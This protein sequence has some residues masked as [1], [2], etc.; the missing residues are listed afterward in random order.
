MSELASSLTL[1]GIVLVDIAIGLI[2]AVLVFSLIAS[3]INE[4]I[5]GV[6]NFRGEHLLKGMARIV[7]SRAVISEVLAQPEI[8]ALS[9]PSNLLQRSIQRLL[10]PKGLTIGT[11]RLPSAI[12]GQTFARSL[13]DALVKARLKTEHELAGSQDATSRALAKINANIDGLE[14]GSEL[15]ARLKEV[16]SRIDPDR[17]RNT[18]ADRLDGTLDAASEAVARRLEEAQVVLERELAEC[19]E[20][21][22]DRVTGWYVRRTKTLLFVIGFSMAAALG[23]DIIGY[24]KRL[25]EDDA[26][27][28]SVLARA[29]QTGRV[30]PL[31]GGALQPPTQANNHALFLQSFDQ[32]QDGQMSPSEAAAAKQ[33]FEAAISELGSEVRDGLATA[34]AQL[35][36]SLDRSFWTGDFRSRLQLVI[37]WMIVGLGCTLGG[38]FWFDL[39]RRLLKVRAGA[40]GLLRDQDTEKVRHS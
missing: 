39:L 28:S 34:R 35:D 30:T 3:A 19:F 23:F 6:L 4:T 7:T 18:L 14:L 37:S 36:I 8:R 16:I 33:S 40:A 21:V 26:L 1:T 2:F 15:K 20:N 17:I 12:P 32:D 13:I 27:R 29:E 24:G 31:N 22:M 9:G 10:L 25:I 38:Q 11:E 5:A